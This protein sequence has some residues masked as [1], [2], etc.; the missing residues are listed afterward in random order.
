MERLFEVAPDVKVLSHCRWQA[1]REAAPTIVLW[2]GIE[3]SS[4]A[5]YMQAV[6]SKAFSDGFNVVRMNLRNCGNTEHL[7]PTIYHGG[8]TDDLRSVV[9]ELI[10][11]D[12][13]RHLFLMGFSLGGNMVLKLAGEYGHNPPREVVGICA[14]SPAVDL[15]A[16]AD[17]INR[18][19]N[20]I[21]QKNFLRR[22]RQ[23]III[24]QRLYPDRYN[25]SG[26]HSIRTIRE[27]DDRITAAAHGFRNADDYYHQASAIHLLGRI[28]IPTLIIHAQDDPFIPFAPLRQPAIAENPYLLLVAPHQG[29]HVA[30]VGAKS[31]HEDRFWAENRAVEFCRMAE[32]NSVRESD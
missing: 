11:R 9:N 29:G 24:K 16:S 8:L 31:G 23:K 14:I 25:I 4:A 19:E 5:N 2:H 1:S 17:A 10:E 21:Y 20:W 7:T 12:G 27:F 28:R 30:F 18:R 6:A 13:L 22:L 26:V 15:G 3:G 32:G